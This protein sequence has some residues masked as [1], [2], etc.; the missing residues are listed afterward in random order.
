MKVLKDY[1][2]KN[3]EG[4]KDL[5]DAYGEKFPD[6][7]KMEKPSFNL[8]ALLQEHFEFIDAFLKNYSMPF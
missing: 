7:L 4:F 6:F 2:E 1:K 8:H 3:P 5:Y